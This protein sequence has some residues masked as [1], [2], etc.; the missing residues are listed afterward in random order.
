MPSDGSYVVVLQYAV[1][2]IILV[3]RTI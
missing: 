2:K 3:G 1:K